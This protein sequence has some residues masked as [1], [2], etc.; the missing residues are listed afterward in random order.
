MALF[1]DKQLLG[2]WKE[3]Q[4]NIYMEGKPPTWCCT[5]KMMGCLAGDKTGIEMSSYHISACSLCACNGTSWGQFWISLDLEPQSQW[6]CWT[7]N[8]LGSIWLDSRKAPRHATPQWDQQRLWWW[9]WNMRLNE[10]HSRLSMHFSAFPAYQLIWYVICW[11]ANKR[12][13]M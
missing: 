13:Y 1:T 10:A 12:K 11:N 2:L 3:N 8:W 9:S 5:P 4:Y 7:Q 6:W